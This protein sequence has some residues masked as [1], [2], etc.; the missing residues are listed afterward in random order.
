MNRKDYENSLSRQAYR[1]EEY[2]KIVYDAVLPQVENLMPVK[3]I[4]DAQK[5]F[6]TGCGDSWLAGV[7]AKPAFESVA[8]METYAP[9][10]IEFSRILNNKNLGYSPNTPLVVL[11]SYSGTASRVVECASRA[12]KY[13][14]NT[15]AITNNS[16]SPLAKACRYCINVGLPADGEY[17]P[18]GTTYNA[19]MLA[20]FILAMWIGRVRGKITPL[21]YQD[22]H[23]ELFK[24]VSANQTKTEEFADRA[25]EIATKWKDQKA[26]DFIGDY[27]DYATAFFGSAKVIECF[28]GYT[29]Y[30][31]SEDWCHINYFLV[32]PDKIGRVVI[33]NKSTPSYG[34]VLETIEAIRK[35][36]S[37]CIIVSDAESGE[38]PD[39]MEVFTTPTPKYFWMNPLAQH[40]P[41]DMVA[42]FIGALKDVKPFR[43]DEEKFNTEICQNRLK[44]GTEI[45]II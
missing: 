11:I 5:V 42:G 14:A 36:E 21:Q 37:P 29:T 33:T 3:E 2:V 25:F 27:G 31:D 41:F 18:G 1:F 32:D 28:G 4:W 6:I 45:K 39:T 19:S 20:L 43:E 35:I 23:S 13:G 12:S 26:Q 15:I 16:D 17:S 38:F 24:F 22:M 8:R 34:R 30:D 9:R 40:L 44:S 7:A 10:A